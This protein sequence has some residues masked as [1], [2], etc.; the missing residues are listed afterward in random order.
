VAVVRDA[1]MYMSGEML[2]KGHVTRRYCKALVSF[3]YAVFMSFEMCR[4]IASSIPV[5]I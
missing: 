4:V 1:I 2:D 3:V 5:S